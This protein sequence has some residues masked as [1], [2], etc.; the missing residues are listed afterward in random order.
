M[1]LNANTTLITS[2]EF[3]GRISNK[4]YVSWKHLLGMVAIPDCSK[5]FKAEPVKTQQ[6]NYMMENNPY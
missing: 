2:T 6:D 3:Q 1:A 5:P 4:G